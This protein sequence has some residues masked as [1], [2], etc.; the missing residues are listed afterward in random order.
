MNT[1]ERKIRTIFDDY[2]LPQYPIYDLT[3]QFAKDFNEWTY[4]EDWHQRGWNTWFNIHKKENS[5]M[6][7]LK[8]IIGS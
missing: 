6:I 1:L 2:V 5:T 3:I 7:H 8:N 4:T